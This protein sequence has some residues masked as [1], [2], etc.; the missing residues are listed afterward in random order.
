M[1][2]DGK[3]IPNVPKNQFYLIFWEGIRQSVIYLTF[4]LSYPSALSLQSSAYLLPEIIQKYAV[5]HGLSRWVNGL[6]A[7]VYLY[8][9]GGRSHNNG[10]S[11]RGSDICQFA[12]KY[13]V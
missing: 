11:L 12:L 8:K 3:F 2:A 7:A 10:I 4:P 13:G 9:A 1:S 5:M 6:Q